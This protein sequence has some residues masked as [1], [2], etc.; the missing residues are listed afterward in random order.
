MHST[1]L[2]ETGD[3]TEFTFIKSELEIG[4]KPS[5]EHKGWKILLNSKPQTVCYS[6]N[7]INYHKLL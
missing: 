3:S 7:K 5:Q 2:W 4:L 1:E 6:Q